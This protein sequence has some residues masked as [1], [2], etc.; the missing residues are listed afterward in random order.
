MSKRGVFI[1]GTDTDVGKT[2]VAARLIQKLRESGVDAVGMKP[3]ECGSYDDSDALRAA[4]GDAG[5]SREQINPI[6]LPDP[7]APAAFS[8][9]PEIDFADLKQRFDDLAE[10][11]DFV[12]VE[13]AGGWLVPVDETR[14]MADLAEQFELPVVIVAA[15]RLGVLNHTLLT[16]R[17]ILDSD[18]S[19]AGV[20]LNSLPDT[21][22]LSCDSNSK[23]LEKNL[24]E[25]PMIDQNLDPLLELCRRFL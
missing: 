1:T 3:I 7:L 20:F 23:V 17:A 25:I 4:S 13:G 19:C 8:E 14:T 12:V 10:A 15:N 18:L 9:V 16:V 6:H 22:D 2:W 24:V 11:H 21:S 5:L